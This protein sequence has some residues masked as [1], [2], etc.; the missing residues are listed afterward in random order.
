MQF[1]TGA[2]DARSEVASNLASS[3]PGRMIRSRPRPQRMTTDQLA[4]AGIARMTVCG[5]GR[6]V[7]AAGEVGHALARLSVEPLSDRLLV[8]D[9]VAAV[10]N[11]L[12]HKPQASSLVLI[13]PANTQ[14]FGG[15]NNP[16]IGADGGKIN[17]YIRRGQKLFQLG[18][19]VEGANN[20]R[21]AR[22]GQCLQSAL[23]LQ[24]GFAAPSEN[25]KKHFIGTLTVATAYHRTTPHSPARFN[26]I[27]GSRCLLAARLQPA[28][29]MDCP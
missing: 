3:E 7:V 17:C 13:N 24:S 29:V 5:A 16:N 25:D 21:R 18:W 26:G 23:D 15:D 20:S 8:S 12:I 9:A 27:S 22:W 6:D 11:G 1:N 4:S 10:T 19:A 28:G 2:R 14:L